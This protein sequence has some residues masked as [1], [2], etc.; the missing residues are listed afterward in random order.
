MAQN[1]YRMPAY[2]GR[3]APSPT[4]PLHRGSLAAA[5]A[6]WLDARA[7]DGK[8]LIRIENIDPPR[9]RPG[10]ADDQLATLARMGMCADEPVMFQSAR[11]RAYE[12]AL[13]RLEQ[14]GRIYRCACSRAQLAAQAG[15]SAPSV[16]PGTCRTRALGPPHAARFRVA[17]GV[18]RFSDRGHGE[19]AQD[20]AR[21]VGDFIVLRAD[22]LWAY[23]LA[24]VVDDAE[25]G[26]SHVVR[27]ADLLDNTPRQIQLQR[28]LGLPTPSYLH[29]PL[30]LGAD[31]N[32]LSKHDGAAPLQAGDPLRELERAWRHLGFA[33]TGATCLQRFQECA[34]AAWRERWATAARS[35]AQVRQAT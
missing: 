7:H 24:V 13:G 6:S 5:L 22:G 31:G 21:A 25:Q 19:F 15:K 27:G 4:G 3:F 9:E 17:P 29:V 12:L 1:V 32:K 26:V 14:A 33:A 2:R 34:V 8:W 11:A 10:A 18:E 23:Q 20:L 16:Y 28:A 30:V 35:V